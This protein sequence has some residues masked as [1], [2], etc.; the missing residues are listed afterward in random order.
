MVQFPSIIFFLDFFNFCWVFKSSRFFV[1]PCIYIYFLFYLTKIW[2]A[3]ILQLRIKVRSIGQHK[4]VVKVKVRPPV[5]RPQV[6]SIL[7][8]PEFIDNKY[9]MVV[10]RMNLSSKNRNFVGKAQKLRLVRRTTSTWK[11]SV[12]DFSDT[13][14]EPTMWL[15]S[16]LYGNQ[17]RCCAHRQ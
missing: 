14:T 3:E 6:S 13:H 17:R 5:Y 11:D 16:A 9:M 2:I 7:R 8:F 1:S 15:E 12:T 4:L 10:I